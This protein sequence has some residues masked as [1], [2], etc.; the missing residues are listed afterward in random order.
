MCRSPR[1]IPYALGDEHE[2]Y[3]ALQQPQETSKSRG[4]SNKR[5]RPSMS[6][7]HLEAAPPDGR[8]L[9]RVSARPS[10]PTKQWI[11]AGWKPEFT[12]LRLQEDKAGECDVSGVDGLIDST[13]SD[14][15]HRRLELPRAE[16]RMPRSLE[17]SLSLEPEEAAVPRIVEEGVQTSG[18]LRSDPHAAYAPL[19]HDGHVPGILGD[20]PNVG[21]MSKE[22]DETTV[23]N[24]SRSKTFSPSRLLAR[25]PPSVPHGIALPRPA[26]S[27]TAERALSSVPTA[28]LETTET[29]VVDDAGAACLIS[30]SDGEGILSPSVAIDGGELLV[31][32]RSSCQAFASPLGESATLDPKIFRG[33]G[34]DVVSTPVPKSPPDAMV[35]SNPVTLTAAIAGRSTGVNS[36]ARTVIITDGGGKLECSEV[37]D[38][39]CGRKRDDKH[40]KRERTRAS[41]PLSPPAPCAPITRVEPR[42][43]EF[44][45]GL[46]SWARETVTVGR[47]ID[48]TSQ[49]VAD[50]LMTEKI[51]ERQIHTLISTTMRSIEQSMPASFFKSSNHVQEAQLQGLAA[52]RSIVLRMMNKHLR[53]AWVR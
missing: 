42:T 18:T 24:P 13:T 53:C 35:T 4:H 47:I 19:R 32:G 43:I 49:R 23:V 25:K 52:V 10:V 26:G 51:R 27:S 22:T 20:Q 21:D 15:Q 44:A 33:A 7:R 28:A 31:G 12:P 5:Q 34:S 39:H 2:D 11:G 46:G 48:E 14:P 8:L 37:D 38:V 50:G 29:E 45:T 3:L 40:A 1:V 17:A 16:E 6:R 36:S 30:Y 9:I 41:R